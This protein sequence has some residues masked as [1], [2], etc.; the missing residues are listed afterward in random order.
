MPDRL[1]RLADDDGSDLGGPRLASLVPRQ[2]TFDLL[3]QTT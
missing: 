1:L 3:V 2:A